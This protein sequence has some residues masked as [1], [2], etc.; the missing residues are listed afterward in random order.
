MIKINA[1]KKFREHF[2]ETSIKSVYETKILGTR[3]IGLDRVDAH[4]FASKLAA[5]TTLISKKVLA[6]TYRFTK[7]KEKL[8]SKGAGKSPRQLSIPT[9]RDRLTLK[10]LC[11]YLFT[12]FPKSKPHLPQELIGDLRNAIDSNKYSYFIKIDLKDF[13]P[14]I[15][16]KLLLSKL[17]KRVRIAPFRNL[18][19]SALENPTVPETNTKSTAA[20][21]QGVAQGLSISNVLAEIFMMDID[22]KIGGLAPICVR[23]VDDIIILT[24]AEPVAVCKDVC[25]ILRKAKLNPHP[26]DAL[27]SK[28]QVGQVS[29]G[30]DFLGY[31]LR[32]KTVS[33]RRSSLTNFESSLVSVFTEYK[34]RFRNA[35][36]VAEKDSALARFRWA[37]NLKLTGCI[38]KNQRFGWVF[39]YSQINDLSVLRRIDNTVSLLCKRFDVTVPPN[40]KRALKAFYESKRTDKESHWYIPN[41]DCITV[42]KMRKFLTE[43]GYKVGG[44]P[45]IEVGFIFHRLVRR[46]TRSLEK[47]VASFS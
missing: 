1:A 42:A 7:Y 33:V 27:G 29:N 9:I 35:K 34:H 14:S 23:F 3:A 13:Y 4:N 25:E 20:N 24:N 37:L 30:L 45:D 8:I 21:S 11:D 32:P 2:S 12:V 19:N 43:I 40:P 47:D 31:S 39:Y 28:T 6:S 44:F 15:N 41:Y 38:Y 17:Y 36:D 22:E 5:E 26:L 18:I 10:I 16:H 46:A